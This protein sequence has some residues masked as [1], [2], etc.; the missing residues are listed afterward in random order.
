M[1]RMIALLLCGFMLLVALSACND[2]GA[3]KAG[4]ETEWSDDFYFD[5]L[6]RCIVRVGHL[7]IPEDSATQ[8]DW[9]DFRRE[10]E[11]LRKAWIKEVWETWMSKLVHDHDYKA[12][13]ALDRI[14][15]VNKIFGGRDI[16]GNYD[17]D[18]F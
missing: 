7:A 9:D 8:T 13:H 12:M 10:I 16:N 4:G 17:A 2:P 5:P 11:H 1:K 15:D 3:E 6:S 14:S 18:T